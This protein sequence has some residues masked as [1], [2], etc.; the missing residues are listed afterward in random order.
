MFAVL[1]LIV[2]LLVSALFMRKDYAIAREVVINQPNDRAF[3][4]LKILKNQENFGSWF[5]L[6]PK[7]K[8]DFSGT[9]GTVGAILS[10]ESDNMQ[11]GVGEQ[12]I[13]KITPNK[14][15]DL[16]LRFKVPFVAKDNP[17]RCDC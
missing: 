16:E 11:V 2:L 12:E 10:W 14:R 4:Y 5:L 7:M 9:D 17:S 8:K 1:G 15:L 6:E 13:M 3:N